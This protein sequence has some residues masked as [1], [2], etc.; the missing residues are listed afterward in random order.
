MGDGY[1]RRAEDVMQVGDEVTVV[2]SPLTIK[3]VWTWHLWLSVMFLWKNLILD[4]VKSANPH[5]IGMPPEILVIV[6]AR[7]IGI[8][9]IPATTAIGAETTTATGAAAT[10]MTNAIIATTET[11]APHHVSRKDALD[12]KM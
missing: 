10:G 12:S 9:E 2:S 1:V 8:T 4:P 5:R 3:T 11:D 6:D 7:T